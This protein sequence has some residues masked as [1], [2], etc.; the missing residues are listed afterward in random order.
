M[1]DSG[2]VT[3]N[4]DPNTGNTIVGPA[5][6]PNQGQVEPQCIDRSA[7]NT[8]YCSCRCANADNK[9]DDGANYC[10][11]PD[12]FSCSQLI[13]PTGTGNEG[14]TGGFCIKTN[15]DYQSFGSC[16]SACD[17]TLDTQNCPPPPIR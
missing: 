1:F 5:G 15:T 16:E 12:G 9:T 8:V 17:P 7:A 10:T 13:A 6:S 14:L 3:P 11:C 4:S 2:E